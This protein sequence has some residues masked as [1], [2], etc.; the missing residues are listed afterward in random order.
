[1]R[2]LHDDL[3]RHAYER[4]LDDP[5]DKVFGAHP[6]WIRDFT[7]APVTHYICRPTQRAAVL[8]AVDECDGGEKLFL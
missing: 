2:K 6:C 3:Q 7:P 5:L 8:E 4:I 1:M